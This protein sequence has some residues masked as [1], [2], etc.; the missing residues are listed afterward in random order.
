MSLFVNPSD[1]KSTL[2][3][4]SDVCN[5]DIDPVVNIDNNGKLNNLRDSNSQW[6]SY[7]DTEVIDSDWVN[8]KF[9]VGKQEIGVNRP[10]KIEKDV[11]GRS[12]ITYLTNYTL[13]SV[14]AYRSTA[15]WKWT[16]TSLGG[17]IAINPRPQFTRY[18]DIRTY[19]RVSGDINRNI[20]VSAGGDV[21]LRGVA[22]QS[23]LGR[24]YSESIDDHQEVIYMQ[25]GVP[26]FNSLVSF[27]TRAISYED[28]TIANTGRYPKMYTLG[29]FAGG[30]IMLAAFPL[31]TA[32]VVVSK[33]AYAFLSGDEAYSYYYMEPTMHTYWGSVN[34][35]VT[36]LA[37]ELGLLIPELMPDGTK[38]NENRIGMPV[39]ISQESVDLLKEYLPGYISDNNYIDVFKIATNAQTMANAQ[40]KREREIYMKDNYDPSLLTGYIVDPTTIHRDTLVDRVDDMISFQDFLNWCTGSGDTSVK[41]SEGASGDAPFKSP[42]GDTESEYSDEKINKNQADGDAGTYGK[43]QEGT[44]DTPSSIYSKDENGQYPSDESKNKNWW[45]KLGESIDS[46]VRGGG[47]YLVLNV[48]YTGSMSDSFNNSVSNIS[49]G[50]AVKSVA[51]GAR[52]ARF[53]LA[54]GNVVGQLGADLL[55]GVKDLAAGVLD[56]VTL[57]LSN[58]LTSLTGGAYVDVPKKWDDSDAQIGSTSYTIDLISPYG[59]PLS[60][61]QN[62]YIPLACI[63]AAALPQKAGEAAYTSPFLCNL[64]NKGKQNVRLGMITSLTI[65]RGTSNLGF[66]KN[67]RPL[68]F[69]VSFTVTDFSNIMTTPISSSLFKMFQTSIND[70]SLLGRYLGTLCSRDLLTDK[71]LIPKLKLKASRLLM[72]KDQATSANN[73]GMFLGDSIFSGFSNVL[74]DMSIALNS[75][76]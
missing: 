24:Y 31:L 54:G 2:F 5:F 49:A 4:L 23:G 33:L 74:H 15:Q 69:K 65:E 28:A 10:F 38:P 61:L 56:S 26:R 63:L 36:Q 12:K 51:Q 47:A 42:N 70:S 35:I 60:Q 3:H 18:A 37:T 71:Y 6:I 43:S 25:F 52:S 72:T 32:V 73:V 48:D 9:M 27:F 1:Y 64:F 53:D 66:T 75:N 55:G 41:G 67:K 58:V 68:A 62:L 40:R 76:N 13:D 17:S 11:N 20:R 19:G 59:N 8:N 34:Y 29:K 45:S 39:K 30:L 7:S 46:T 21:H 14:N 16:N 44:K 50:D 57:G 22:N